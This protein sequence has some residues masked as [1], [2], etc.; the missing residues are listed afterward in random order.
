MN[1]GITNIHVSG[2]VELMVVRMLLTLLQLVMPLQ[3]TSSF[4]FK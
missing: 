3:K 1:I 2:V 4:I